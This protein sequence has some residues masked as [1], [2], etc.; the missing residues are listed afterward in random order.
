MAIVLYG[1]PNCDTVKKARAW[2]A[3]RGVPHQFHDFKKQGVP[4]ERL[5]AWIREVGWQSLLNRKGTTWRK[6]DTPAQASAQDAAGAKALM[7][8]HPSV[9]KRP[10]VEWGG[11]TTV[12]FDAARWALL[13]GR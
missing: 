3:E 4:S 11:Q 9:I 5:D 12:G 7:L 6:L 10:V 8:A 1:V 2:L 13:A